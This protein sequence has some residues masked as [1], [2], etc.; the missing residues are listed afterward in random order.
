MMAALI[1]SKIQALYLQA[2]E[3][4]TPLRLS[5]DCSLNRWKE[6]TWLSQGQFFPVH[7]TVVALQLNWEKARVVL[8][9]QA[10]KKKSLQKQNTTIAQVSILD[11]VDHPRSSSFIPLDAHFLT[12][13]G[14]TELYHIQVSFLK[15]PETSSQPAFVRLW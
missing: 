4:D 15:A 9:R 14:L 1:P 12:A 8:G 11:K 6:E 13:S 2:S 10:E 7:W 5:S 3:T